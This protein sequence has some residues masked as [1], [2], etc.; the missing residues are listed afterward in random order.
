MNMT[1]LPL[2]GSKWITNGVF[3]IFNCI[4]ISYDCQEA[5]WL[6]YMKMRI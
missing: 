6:S 1:F 5:S 4:K 3:A 2:A